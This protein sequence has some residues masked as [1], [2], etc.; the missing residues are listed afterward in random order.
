MSSPVHGHEVIAMIRETQQAYTR[1]TLVAA[2]IAR[3]GA[4]T[5]FFTCSAQGMTAGELV[6]FLDSRGKFMP[7][8]GGFT[9]DPARVCQH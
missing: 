1:E 6:D 2:I 3:F 8:A 7:Q 5:Q 4:T 9:V